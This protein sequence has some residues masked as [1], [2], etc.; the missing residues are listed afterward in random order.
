MSHFDTK[1]ATEYIVKSQS[2]DG[3]IGLG[4]NKEGHG[5]STFTGVASLKLMGTLEQLDVELLTRWCMLHQGQ[6]FV[7]RP[8]KPPD[9][10]Y[11]FWVGGTLRILG[12]YDGYV[13][14]KGNREF[15]YT[16]EGSTGGFGKHA[17]SYADIL[18]SYYGLCG[19]S[20]MGQ[21]ELQPVNV[22]MQVT[23]RAFP[24]SSLEE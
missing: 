7:G 23:Q 2:Y 11:S 3:A 19:L 18:H 21:D 14:P 9:T 5:G 16:C 10:C 20:L 6:G 12:M 15:V 8:N 1:K 4:P 13:E 22:L 17:D 24:L